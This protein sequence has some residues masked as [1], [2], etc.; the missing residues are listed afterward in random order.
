MALK[1]LIACEYSGTVRDAFIKQ[2]HDAVSCDI[3]PGEIDMF[4]HTD[5]KHYQ[6]SVFDIINDGFDMLIAHPPC[7]FLS[8]VG[9]RHWNKPGRAEKRQEAL[10]FFLAL[11]NCNIPKIAIEN[12]MGF[13]G[14]FVPY[15]QIIHPYYFGDPA[16]KRTCLWLKNLPKLT[17]PCVAELIEPKPVYY[18]KSTGK[19]MH[20][21]E[22]NHG[23]HKR[24][25]TFQGIANAMAIQWGGVVLKRFKALLK[26]FFILGMCAVLFC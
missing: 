19:A 7:T 14:K 11:W 4:N 26:G 5:G 9:N 24:S 15:S 12:P 23:G 18:L 6:G 22:A 3:L 16:K 1:V 13:A 25:K 10:E 2:G 17:H 20:W 21:T 8:Y